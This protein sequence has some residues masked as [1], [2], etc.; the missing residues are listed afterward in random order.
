MAHRVLLEVMIKRGQL[1]HYMD[2]EGDMVVSLGR[3][4]FEK[5]LDKVVR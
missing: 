5:L 4:V 3:L 2:I 1:L